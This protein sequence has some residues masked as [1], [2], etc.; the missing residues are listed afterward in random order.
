[1]NA[2]VNNSNVQSAVMAEVVV[3]MAQGVPDGLGTRLIFHLIDL[4]HMAKMAS[5]GKAGDNVYMFSL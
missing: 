1:M 5:S 3:V 4:K 2:K